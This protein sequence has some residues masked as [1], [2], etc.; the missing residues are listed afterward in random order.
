[1]TDVGG[2]HTVHSAT[3][4]RSTSTASSPRLT[5]QVSMGVIDIVVFMGRRY[6]TGVTRRRGQ[7]EEEMKSLGRWA[8]RQDRNARCAMG[9]AR[10]ATRN[11]LTGNRGGSLFPHGA[12]RPRW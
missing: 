8:I 9:D 10:E 12:Q 7:G 3:G 4:H 6:G 5:N 11:G 1:M 2:P